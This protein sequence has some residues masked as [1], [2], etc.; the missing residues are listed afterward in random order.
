MIID[1]TQDEVIEILDAVG[2]R[3]DD[4][5]DCAMFGDATEIMGEIESLQ[6]LTCKLSDSLQAL[7]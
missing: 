7:R 2:N 1:L 5:N 3:I 6:T 4:L